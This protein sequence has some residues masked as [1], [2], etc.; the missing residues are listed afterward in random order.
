MTPR[1]RYRVIETLDSGLADRTW[2]SAL[3]DRPHEANSPRWRNPGHEADKGA[4]TKTI[5]PR[6]MENGL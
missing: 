3:W 5:A 1:P 2:G 6:L 4:H